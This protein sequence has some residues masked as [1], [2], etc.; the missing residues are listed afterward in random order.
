MYIST[1]REIKQ[2]VLII[3]AYTFAFNIQNF[4]QHS[5]VKVNTICTGNY[6]G[7]SMWIL[8]QQIN[9][10]SYILFIDFKTAY[11]SVRRVVL[12]NLIAL[13][14]PMKL[15]RLIKMCPNETYSRAHVGMHLCDMLPIRN[16][17]K[18]GDALL[19]FLFNFA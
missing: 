10:E 4:I 9:Y 2:T 12:Y 13:G 19:P 7:S 8:M 11:D 16:G 17:L 1:R 3:E 14:I 6:W 18:Q 5:A 15:V